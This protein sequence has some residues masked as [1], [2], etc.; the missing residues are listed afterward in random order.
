MNVDAIIAEKIMGWTLENYDT[1]E[2][3]T[4]PEHY[5]DASESDGWAWNGFDREAWQW[6]PTR[7]IKQAFEV[8]EKMC[9]GPSP[10]NSFHAN[11][12]YSLY[13]KG[14][15]C[16]FERTVFIGDPD[17]YFAEAK[18]PAMAICLAA[19]LIIGVVRND[20]PEST[21]EQTD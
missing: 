21:S 9:H 7:N 13:R 17:E 18:T 2:P 8:L 16:N 19:L 14:Y 15:W 20:E 1:Y 3:A 12:G 5:K 6:Q 10:R 4:T 11:V